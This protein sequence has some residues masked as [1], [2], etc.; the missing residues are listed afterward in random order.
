MIGAWG[1][2]GGGGGKG[3]GEGGKEGGEGG[4]AGK[5][6]CHAVW[7]SAATTRNYRQQD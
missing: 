4:F 1:G 3:G 2:G 5:H 6:S 7:V